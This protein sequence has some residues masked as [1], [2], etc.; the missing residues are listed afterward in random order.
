ME[1]PHIMVL[2]DDP[3]NRAAAGDLAFHLGV[4]GTFQI[5]VFSHSDTQRLPA[6]GVKLCVC[7]RGPGFITRQAGSQSGV[8]DCPADGQDEDNSDKRDDGSSAV[9][10]RR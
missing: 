5:S 4:V 9:S 3:E 6:D 1:L 10:E 8:Q 7:G 2:I